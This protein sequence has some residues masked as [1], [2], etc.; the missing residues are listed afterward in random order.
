ML[1]DYKYSIGRLVVYRHLNP[2]LP[3]QSYGH[4]GSE[5]TI[6]EVLS[7]DTLPAPEPHWVYT[8][9]NARNGE[10]SRVRESEILFAT[11]TASKPTLRAVER[12]AE[13][14]ALAEMIARA[15]S[16]P[17]RG[18]L[19]RSTLRDLIRREE[20]EA[21]ARTHGPNLPIG[22]G[23]YIRVRGDLRP[24]TQALHNHYAKVLLVEDSD[25]AGIENSSP[26]PGQPTILRTLR[27]YEIVSSE[28]ERASIY[29]AEVKLFYT[30]NSRATILNWRAATLLAE[31]FGDAPPYNVEYEFLSDHVFTR[32]EIRRKPRAELTQLLASLLYVKGRMGW[33]DYQRRNAFFA[34]TPKSHLIDSI[35]L[36]SRFDSRRNRAMTSEE[37]VRRRQEPFKLRRLLK[38]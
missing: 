28:G 10:V 3:R 32:E 6:G 26:R 9:Q 11:G 13:D 22:P 19:L 20:S 15:L 33:R 36:V 7:V 18:S 12:K 34:G 27:R 16:N 5:K 30:A 23:D 21:K 31:A 2:K 35:L 14:G 8:I 17:E 29:D 37:I 38:A 1:D 24:D 4:Y 25:I